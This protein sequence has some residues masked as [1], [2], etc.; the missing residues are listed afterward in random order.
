MH[1]TIRII[2]LMQ[3]I[4]N[5]YA[6]WYTECRKNKGVH[7]DIDFTVYQQEYSMLL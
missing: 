1:K 4:D 6:I 7:N 2:L 3:V 5:V